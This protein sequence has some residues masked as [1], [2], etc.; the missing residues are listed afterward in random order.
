MTLTDIET[1]NRLAHEA[2]G[3]SLDELSP[4]TRRLLELVAAM[5][6]RH[7]AAQAISAQRLSL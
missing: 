6:E 4:Q 3:R 7:C 5:V 2:L 1:A